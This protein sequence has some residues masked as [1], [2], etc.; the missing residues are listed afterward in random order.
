MVRNSY[1]GLAARGAA[2]AIDLA[3]LAAAEF[4]LLFLPASLFFAKAL[5]HET[6]ATLTALPLFVVLLLGGSV[7]L[8]MA[9][10]TL[11]HA[12]TGQTIGKTILGLRVVST[13]STVL[14]PGVA[15]LRWTGYLLSSVPLA[16]GFLWAAVDRD[17]CAWHDRLART[18]VVSIEMT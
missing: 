1:P 4:L 7:L 9:Y 3:L 11:F 16:A 13:D 12:L 15:F 14:S 10:F 5:F 18:R 8:H 6:A 2:L 17:H